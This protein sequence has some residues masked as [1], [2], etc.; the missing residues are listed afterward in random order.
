MIGRLLDDMG[1]QAGVEAANL[2]TV[3]IDEKPKTTKSYDTLKLGI[4]AVTEPR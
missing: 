4:A 3:M 1:C 2:T